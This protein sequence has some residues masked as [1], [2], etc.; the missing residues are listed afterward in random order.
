VVEGAGD[1]CCEYMTGGSITV[2][3]ATGY[4]FGAGMTGGFAYVLDLNKDF[5]DKYNHE[6]VEVHRIRNEGMEEYRNHLRT[7]IEEFVAETD[8]AWGQEIL[9]NYMEYLRKFWLVKPKAASLKMLL[10]YVTANPQ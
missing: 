1:H 7:V 6:L 8:S 2:L 5:V 9:D 10:S 4:N 3:G